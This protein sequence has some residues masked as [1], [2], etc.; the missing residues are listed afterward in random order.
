MTFISIIAISALLWDRDGACGTGTV[1][2]VHT[3]LGTRPAARR[4]G[5]AAA[6]APGSAC[7]ASTPCCGA[8]AWAAA[9]DRDGAYHPRYRSPWLR[10]G[11][12]VQEDSRQSLRTESTYAS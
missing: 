12:R 2:W 6:A 10:P 1:Q 7:S 8:A 5:A 11:S 4:R 3:I 9:P